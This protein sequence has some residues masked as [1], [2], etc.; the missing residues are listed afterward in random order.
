[1]LKES[2]QWQDHVHLVDT[3]KR[4]PETPVRAQSR[5]GFHLLDKKRGVRKME[6]MTYKQNNVLLLG[7]LLTTS[8][9]GFACL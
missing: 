6:V 9:G 4:A 5:A 3:K 7:L 2:P 1:M 8:R